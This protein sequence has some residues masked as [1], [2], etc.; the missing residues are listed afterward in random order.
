MNQARAAILKI[1]ELQ[2]KIAAMDKIEITN[3]LTL[4]NLQILAKSHSPTLPE[5]PLTKIPQAFYQALALVPLSRS[6]F[7]T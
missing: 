2:D 3:L 7:L 5:I 6:H 4:K 1:K